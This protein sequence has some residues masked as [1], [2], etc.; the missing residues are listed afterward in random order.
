MYGSIGSTPADARGLAGDRRRRCRRQGPIKRRVNFFDTR[1]V[2]AA[3]GR[4]ASA[5]A[6]RPTALSVVLAA[7]GSFAVSALLRA[8]EQRLALAPAPGAAVAV[9][10]IAAFADEK[11]R[12]TQAANELKQP[13]LIAVTAATARHVR[14]ADG[15]ISG[16]R[17]QDV[18]EVQATVAA[19]ATDRRARVSRPGPSSLHVR[20]S[21]LLAIDLG[22]EFLDP[23]TLKT[24]SERAVGAAGAAP[25]AH[26]HRRP[27]STV[28]K[29]RIQVAA[30]TRPAMSRQSS[31]QA[32]RRQQSSRPSGSGRRSRSIPTAG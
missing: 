2:H 24:P 11:T 30:D 9:T 6:V 21:E 17:A 29:T 13:H 19:S 26:A 14:S 12:S 28:M 32:P 22:R 31:E 7:G 25:T 3:G 5:C 8:I 15:A 4:L 27:T 16:P 18:A 10:A 20:P 1:V 23:G